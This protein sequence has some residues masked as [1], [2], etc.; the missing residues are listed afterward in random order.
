[1]KGTKKESTY[2]RK[3]IAK[4][5]G[6][7]NTLINKLPFELHLP[8]YQYC[9]PGTKLEKRLARGDTG[10]NLLDQACKE[11][12]IAYSQKKSVEDRR[13]ADKILI[14]KAWNRV[15]SPDAKFG[16]KASALLVTNMMK[17]K[18]KM[19]MGAGKKKQRKVTFKSAV[20]SAKKELKEKKPTT[21]QKSIRLAL[22]AAKR[23]TKKKQN[24]TKIK[25]PRVIQ[26]PKNGG[27][28][29]LIPIFAGLSALGALS[30]GAAGIA[31]AVNSAKNAKAKLIESTRHNKA[32]EDIAMGKGLYLK[33]YK[34]G[35]G[36][37]LPN[38]KN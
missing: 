38:Q 11:H 5:K 26:V 6:V 3:Q 29:P 28:L 32:M 21:V 36:L 27:I 25:I 2:S 17:A 7:I 31:S 30:G 33:P 18:V 12:D 15:K 19:G 34:T 24:K 10:K 8:G 1:M 35:L 37:Y 22:S 23:L 16:E 4:G 13:D 9:G 14:E 20:Q